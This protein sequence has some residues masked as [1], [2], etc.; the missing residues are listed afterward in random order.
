MDTYAIIKDGIVI[1]IVDYDQDPGNPPPGFDDSC[2]AVLA[3]SS[4]PGWTY[5]NGVLTAPQP[6][7]SWVLVDNVWM[8]SSPMPQDGK[9]YKWDESTLS[10]VEL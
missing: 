10:W 8:A 3:G 6:Y 9:P 5:A 7:P 1:N 4:G 2:I